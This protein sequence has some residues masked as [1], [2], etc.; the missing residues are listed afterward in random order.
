MLSGCRVEVSGS[1]TVFAE[2]RVSAFLPLPLPPPPLP[3]SPAS[4]RS[5][6][7]GPWMIVRSPRWRFRSV[8][9]AGTNFRGVFW[10]VIGG[11]EILGR[12][13]NSEGKVYGF[14]IRNWVCF[15]EI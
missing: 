12:F 13:W 8:E 3:P 4:T 11:L 14:S 1:V 6:A 10:N 7:I 9:V 15:G 5:L 2:K